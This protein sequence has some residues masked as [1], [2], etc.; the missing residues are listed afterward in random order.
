[1]LMPLYKISKYIRSRMY[2]AFAF[3]TIRIQ[4][5]LIRRTIVLDALFF[6]NFSA[7]IFI[8]LL[9]LLLFLC[10]WFPSTFSLSLHVRAIGSICKTT[11][12]NRV[13]G[14]FWW[15]C[16]CWCFMMILQLKRASEFRH[17]I[18]TSKMELKKEWHSM[19]SI[20]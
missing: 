15:C 18:S 6:F 5:Y 16:C 17:F 4:F 7:C 12:A 9:L 1:M 20:C 13:S 8:V 11:P 2:L 3:S 14:F 10:C 19:N